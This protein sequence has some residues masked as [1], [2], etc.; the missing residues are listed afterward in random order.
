MVHAYRPAG[1]PA[2]RLINGAFGGALQPCNTLVVPGFGGSTYHVTVENFDVQDGSAT[3]SIGGGRGRFIRCLKDAVSV[4]E[5]LGTHSHS[6][7]GD[8]FQP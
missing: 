7:S 2:S 6:R 1:P 5:K 3:V 8:T 4:D